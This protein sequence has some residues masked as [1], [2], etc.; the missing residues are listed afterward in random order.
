MN[1]ETLKALVVPAKG[2][3]VLIT[4]NSEKALAI[5]LAELG[6]ENIPSDRRNIF[7]ERHM[8]FDMAIYYKP[9]ERFIAAT[10]QLNR[11]FP[12]IGGR[13]ESVLFLSEGSFA[14]GFYQDYSFPPKALF[15]ADIIAHF[16]LNEGQLSVYGFD[17]TE[18]KSGLAQLEEETK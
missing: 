9:V 18:R 11:I 13:E 7:I 15:K 16:E 3:F 17:R 4:G 2:K 6:I 1:I 14:K 10:K 12:T 8:N 5:G